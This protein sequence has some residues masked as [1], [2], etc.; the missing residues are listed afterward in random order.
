MIHSTLYN[1]FFVEHAYVLLKEFL[2]VFSI[3][4]LSG[5]HQMDGNIDSPSMRVT[6]GPLIE[7]FLHRIGR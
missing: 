2:V 6:I 5:K 7:V 1:V 4:I 3:H